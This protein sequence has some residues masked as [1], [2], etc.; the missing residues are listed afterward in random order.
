MGLDYIKREWKKLG[1]MSLFGLGAFLIL[2]HIYTY[3]F[4]SLG[5]F[6]GHEWLGIVLLILGLIFANKK[7]S[8]KESRIQYAINKIKSLRS[9]NG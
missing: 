6:L 8:E 9:S 3:G 2:E 7:W 4:I 5:D 1:S